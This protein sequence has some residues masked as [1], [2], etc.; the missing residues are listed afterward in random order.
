MKW[1][2]ALKWT[3]RTAGVPP[4]SVDRRPPACSAGWKPAE[5]NAGRMPAVL[6]CRRDACGPQMKWLVLISILLAAAVSFS[7]EAA[8]L[9]NQAC[10]V[11]HEELESK[12]AKSVHAGND[13]ISCHT[14]ITEVP[15]NEHLT[16]VDCS[17]C[18]SDVADVYAKSSHGLA[19]A[20]K[21]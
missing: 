18:H 2:C 19:K 16:A 7:E 3:Q 11:C 17:A 8:D 10:L 6:R 14:D 15:H 1:K 9:S 5:P 13:C 21:I 20:R 4:A 12:Y